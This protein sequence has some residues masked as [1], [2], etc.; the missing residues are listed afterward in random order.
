M[1]WY[2]CATATGVFGH[3]VERSIRRHEGLERWRNGKHDGD[4]KYWGSQAETYL[5]LWTIMA[6]FR[7]K[8]VN[9]QCNK[10]ECWNN[11]LSNFSFCRIFFAHFRNDF[12]AV[13]EMI[14][15]DII[16][17]C[18]ERCFRADSQKDNLFGY[19]RV[20]TNKKIIQLN[21]KTTS[22]IQSKKSI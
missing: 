15:Y 6:V 5:T 10:R 16:L 7:I 2:A 8:A 3:T 9:M 1:Y 13:Y 18:I 12:C 21:F 20:D 14:H 11:I 17:I 22:I 19:I 4:M